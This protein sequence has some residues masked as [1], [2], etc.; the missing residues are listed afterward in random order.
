MRVFHPQSPCAWSPKILKLNYLSQGTFWRTNVRWSKGWSSLLLLLDVGSRWRDVNFVYF[1]WVHENK[2]GMHA[3]HIVYSPKDCR[4]KTRSS[5]TA[6]KQHNTY[7]CL[8]SW[9]TDRAIH[10]TLQ[11]LCNFIT[12]VL[13]IV[14][15]SVCP[16]VC[17]SHTG[18]ESKRLKLR[19]WGLHSSFQHAW[20]HRKIPK[21]TWGAR[22]P[23]ERGVW[24][25]GNF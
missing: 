13:A 2:I 12:A 3:Q 7:A 18:T 14:N 22:A 8:S 25:I 5:V 10:W 23:N 24:K 9:L 16:S 15:P 6:E 4:I 20:L 19:S 17:P 11:L 21:G 1:C